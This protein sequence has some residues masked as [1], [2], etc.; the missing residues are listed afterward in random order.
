M[1]KRAFIN[2]FIAFILLPVSFLIKIYL[3]R[4]VFDNSYSCL[5][6]LLNFNFS[7]IYRGTYF[8]TTF[9]YILHVAM[10]GVIFKRCR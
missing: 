6:K 3:E 9:I 2:I 10:Y 5:N 8:V 7:S 4:E 1:K